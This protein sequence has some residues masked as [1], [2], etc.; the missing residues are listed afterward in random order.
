[1]KLLPDTEISKNITQEIIID[2]I[3]DNDG[4]DS[5]NGLNQ[6]Y[7][8]TTFGMYW[9]STERNFERAWAYK[10]LSGDSS[11]FSKDDTYRVR[12][13]RAF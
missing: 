2:Q 4:D 12:A 3:L 13:I 8:R 9:S 10:A 11:H 1:M 7:D 5:T 6:E